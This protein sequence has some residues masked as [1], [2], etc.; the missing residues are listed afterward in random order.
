[1]YID[2]DVTKADGFLWRLTSFFGEPSMEKKDL[3]W[4]AL[5]TLNAVRQCLWLCMGTLMKSSWHV[6]RRV[7]S[8]GPNPAW[9]ISVRP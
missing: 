2:A 9:T 6:R 1:M 4:Q 8:R 7:V 5:C 3:S